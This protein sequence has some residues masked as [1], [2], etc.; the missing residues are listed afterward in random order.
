MDQAPVSAQDQP[1][2]S[3]PSGVPLPRTLDQSLLLDLSKIN[4]VELIKQEGE[5][6]DEAGGHDVGGIAFAPPADVATGQGCIR[7][8]STVDMEEEEAALMLFSLSQVQ[9]QATKGSASQKD[10]TRLQDVSLPS[11]RRQ[12]P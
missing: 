9:P 6:V 1:H 11:F 7:R 3:P 5:P 10:L 4:D 12:S 8:T 2:G